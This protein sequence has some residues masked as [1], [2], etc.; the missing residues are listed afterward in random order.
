MAFNFLLPHFDGT[1]E[2]YHESFRS[3]MLDAA[4]AVPC[5]HPQGIVGYLLSD[6]EF[7]AAFGFHFIPMPILDGA[8][9]PPNTTPLERRVRKDWETDYD[10]Y[11]VCEMPKHNFALL[12]LPHSMNPYVNKFVVIKGLHSP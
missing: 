5:D 11:K 10:K 4:A 6:D 1:A 7:F 12:S 3:S 2:T 8:N 9:A